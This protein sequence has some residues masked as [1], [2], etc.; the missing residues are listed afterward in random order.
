MRLFFTV[1]TV[2]TMLAQPVLANDVVPPKK[3]YGIESGAFGI[4]HDRK[5]CESVMGKGVILGTVGEINSEQSRTD[6]NIFFEGNIYLIVVINEW[7]DKQDRWLCYKFR[8]R[9]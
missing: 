1:A 9:K 3:F 6:T 2:L 4:V 5:L 8:A 7:S